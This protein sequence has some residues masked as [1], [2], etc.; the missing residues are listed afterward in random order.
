MK[1]RITKTNSLKD[2]KMLAEVYDQLTK[3][4]GPIKFIVENNALAFTEE[5]FEWEIFFDACN[6][7]RQ[8]HNIPSDDYLIVLTNLRDC[9]NWFSSFSMKRGNRTAFIHSQNWENFIFCEPKYPIAYS[10]LENVIQ[11]KCYEELGEIFFTENVHDN[12]RGC[13]NDMCGW[14]SDI[15]FKMR[16]GDICTDCISLLENIYE[17]KVIVQIIE[18]FEFFRKNMVFNKNHQEPLSFEKHLPFTIAIT[19]RKMS[20]T[21]DSFR[22]LLLLIDH[23]DSIIRTAVI[24]FGNIVLGKESFVEFT[25]AAGLNHHPSLGHWVSALQKISKD[26]SSK[27]L[28]EFDIPDSL[29][30]HLKEISYFASEEGIVKMRNEKRGHGY[31][32]CNNDNYKSEFERCMEVVNKM[33]QKIGPLLSQFCYYHIISAE[34]IGAGKFSITALDLTGSNPSFVE[35]VMSQSFVSFNETPIK[36]NIYAKSDNGKWLSLSPYLQY[37]ICDECQHNRVL[38]YDGIYMLDPFIGHR[39]TKKEN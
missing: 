28:L 18:F 6:N 29:N 24:V 19:K 21:Q 33:E 8:K 22:K 12:T 13:M 34:H 38:I 23:F 37:G 36:G 32:S 35:K 15:T 39:F 9:K 5:S 17:N 25:V 4:P 20:T 2:N 1:I 27:G 14:K 16:T 10:I 11:S 7:Y 30:K 26:P 31:I 3:I